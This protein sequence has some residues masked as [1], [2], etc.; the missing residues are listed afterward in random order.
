MTSAGGQ[1]EA[2]GVAGVEAQLQLGRLALDAA[3]EI[4]EAA[5]ARHAIGDLPRLGRQARVVGAEQ[6]DLDRPGR[7]GEI[8]EDVLEHLH[9]LDP[10][11][12]DLVLHALA[13]LGDH[14]LGRLLPFRMRLEA[15]HDVAATHLGRRRGPELGAGAPRVGGDVRERPQHGLDLPGGASVS[16]SEVPAGRK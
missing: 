3:I 6:L 2:G 7:S 15:H 4:D 13:G 14:L 8:V 16:T 12:R 11:L 10:R 1:P 5:H 9:E